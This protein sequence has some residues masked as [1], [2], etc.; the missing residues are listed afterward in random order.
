MS[1][2]TWAEVDRYVSQRLIGTD[3]DL[4][5]ALA[6]S[7]A[8]GLPAIAVSAPQGKLLH[9]MARS[10]NARRILEIGTLGGYST[11]WLARALPS[12]GR[13]VTL[14]LEERH[15]NV[16]RANLDRAGVGDQV[17][18]R[19]GPALETLPAL[20]EDHLEPFDMVFIDADKEN[21]PAYFDWSLR[22][23][24]HGGVIIVDNVVRNG[25]LV[26]PDEQ[27]PRVLGVRA[28]HELLSTRPGIEA[29]TIQ[30]VGA[31]GYDGFTY[32][33]VND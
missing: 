17:E 1:E 29:T 23:I 3:D 25:G 7:E 19:I 5:A 4:E 30:T 6:A 26:D 32:A 10:I 12:G 16:A 24:R 33:V 27:D 9:L 31:K 28:F 11:I 8:A 15:A 13:L 2:Q 20:A 14:E 21:I 18:I 22:L